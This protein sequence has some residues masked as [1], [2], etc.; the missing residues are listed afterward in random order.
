M[1]WF[2]QVSD[3]S[4]ATVLWHHAVECAVFRFRKR[5]QWRSRRFL[6]AFPIAI[7]PSPI[8]G[9]ELLGYKHSNLKAAICGRNRELGG[10]IVECVD[11][12]PSVTRSTDKA[13]ENGSVLC[14]NVARGLYRG[15]LR[16]HCTGRMP[17]FVFVSVCVFVLLEPKS[18]KL[19]YL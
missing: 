19:D 18:F 11:A 3:L 7:A 12:L 9:S 10:C 8:V 15:G 6:V 5:K 16:Q 1:M 17:G 4:T 13:V 2:R 14:W